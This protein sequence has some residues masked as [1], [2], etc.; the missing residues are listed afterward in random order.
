MGDKSSINQ[1]DFISIFSKY[2]GWS[3]EKNPID[4]EY[5]KDDWK[6]QDHNIIKG[7]TYRSEQF[8][9]E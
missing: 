3:N 7:T 5:P 6:Y 2:K 8:K 4:A 9:Y 1:N